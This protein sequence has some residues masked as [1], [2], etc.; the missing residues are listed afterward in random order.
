M[1]LFKK[2]ISI[3]LVMQIITCCVAPI[4]YC[5][6]MMGGWHKNTGA[7]EQSR[8]KVS[9]IV[10][11]YNVEP[12][13]REC[14][15]SIKNQ[16]LKN[17]E[18]ICVDDGSPDNCGQILD[19]YAE[20][21]KRFVVIHQKNA[22]VQEARN[23]GLARAT[24]E[25]I[26]F[27]DSDDY[28][29]LDAYEVAYK[30]IKKDNVDIVEFGARQFIDGEDDH[31][32]PDNDYSDGEILS[33]DAYLL[34]KTPSWVWDKLFKPELIKKDNVKFIKDLRPC[35]DTCF[36]YMVMG[37]A[38]NVKILPTKLYNLRR[39]RTDSITATT[40]FTEERFNNNYKMLKCVYDDWKKYGYLKGH[41]HVLL[42]RFMIW[43][44]WNKPFSL[45]HARKVLDSFGSDIYNPEIIKKCDKLTQARIRELED[46][47]AQPEKYQN[48][49]EPAKTPAKPAYRR[50]SVPQRT[51][52]VPKKAS[53]SKR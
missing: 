37:R 28:L 18:S 25:Y 6:E 35:D 9:V 12:Y 52:P 43:A 48:K 24:G 33:R 38:K 39:G 46:A 19:E 4:A 49:P 50:S 26:T 3:F 53:T 14:L 8:P 21:D 11:V 10:P 44:G 51:R 29:Q 23:A 45:K 34:K 40:P 42:Y 13:L 2:L 17:F 20:H 32:I 41:E 36:S 16:T 7:S 31:I 27:V 30:A 22:G 5:T 47:A 1:K 15:D